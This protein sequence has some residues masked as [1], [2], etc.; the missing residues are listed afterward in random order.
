MT[1]DD[2]DVA[3]LRRCVV[4]A[5]EAR[6]RGDE[7]FGSV[8]VSGE[9]DVLAEDRNAVVT[10]RDVTAHPE[11]AMARW[12]S[13]H[14]D[15]VERAAATLYTSCEHCAMCAGAQFWAGV[16]RLVFAL[17]SEQLAEHLPSGVPTLA[18]SCR[19]VFARGSVAITVDGP[20]AAVEAEAR[21]AVAGYWG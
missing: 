1:I 10:T 20:V 3:H 21:A 12:A 15:P 5:S 9:G 6:A 7:P 8:L 2:A 17:S 13:L 14:L 4:L 11:L 16:G 19:E 18:L